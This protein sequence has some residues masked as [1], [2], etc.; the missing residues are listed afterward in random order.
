[1]GNAKTIAESIR[2]TAVKM[3]ADP[4]LKNLFQ[5]KVGV[6][7]GKEICPDPVKFEKMMADG[8]VDRFRMEYMQNL[9]ALGKQ[10]ELQALSNE[11]QLEN[12]NQK[13][14]EMQKAPL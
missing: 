5:D 2:N 1:M 11:V 6:L 3:A 14:Q 4:I 9:K 8:G 10:N 12:Q 7:T 13:Q